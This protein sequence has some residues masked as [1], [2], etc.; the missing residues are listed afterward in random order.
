VLHRARAEQPEDEMSRPTK[1]I[2]ALAALL[3]SSIA[4]GASLAV[5]PASQSQSWPDVKCARYKKG[6]SDALA[7]RG[8]RG[9]GRKFLDSH[10]AFLASGCM[11]RADVCPQ[12]AEELDLANIMVIVAMN[13]GTAS[14]FP[15]FACRK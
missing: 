5:T 15:P 9:L 7:R 12:S 6:W 8:T 4:S 10:L 3:A 13:A 2:A 14:T 11:A 1:L